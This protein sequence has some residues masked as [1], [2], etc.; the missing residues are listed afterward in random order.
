M[1]L[2][3]ITVHW[4][5]LSAKAVSIND[6]MYVIHNPLVLHPTW[7]SVERFLGEV[8][9][10]STVQGYYQ[11]LTMI[12]LMLD[13]VMGG[14][15]D[16]LRPYHRTS[17]AI[18]A[19]NAALIVILLYMLLG[20][21][22]SA[23]FA[24]LLFGLHP[25]TVET[26]AWCGERK[27]LLATC[28]A[29]LCLI[30]YIRYTRRPATISF[31]ASVTLFLLALMSKPTVTPL[32]VMLLLLDFWP[33]R[34]ISGRA[35]IEKVPFFVLAGVFAIITVV[36]Q[37]HLGIVVHRHATVLQHLLLVCHNLFFYPLKMLWPIPLSSVYPFPEPIGLSHPM[38]LAGL[39]GTC[40][41][42]ALAIASLRWTRA[43]VTCWLLFFVAL[44]PTLLNIKYAMGVAADKYAYLPALGFLIFLAWGLGR[45]T[46][47]AKAW[48]WFAGAA[49]LG[50]AICETALTRSYITTWADTERLCRHVLTVAP[51][52]EWAHSE[53]AVQLLASDD[54]EKAR[55]HASKALALAPG[56]QNAHSA[57]GQILMRQGKPDQAAGHFEQALAAKPDLAE[58]R[59]N[60][61]VCLASTRQLDRAVDQMKW[62]LRDNPRLPEAHFNLGLMLDQQ[63]H[64]NEAAD[65]FAEAINQKPAYP[66]AHFRLAD[67]LSRQGRSP[68]A[69]D[70]YREALKARPDEPAILTHLGIELARANQL[71]EA[72]S[73]LQRA[74]ELA[75]GRPDTHTNLGQALMQAGRLEEAIPQ[76]RAALAMDPNSTKAKAGL[77]AA[78]NQQMPASRPQ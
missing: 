48:Q 3:A 58:A 73:H 53:L 14:S 57:M 35:V 28:F 33:L 77:D 20:E 8:R 74:V 17:L 67:V 70:H 12:S 6:G 24:G 23:A 1:F 45:L 37:Q 36:S 4:P 62:A 66:E 76:Y 34:R 41:M 29:L 47:R 75:P 60:L 59:A 51:D 54:L 21:P 26:M 18:H 64:L 16:N 56:S 43:V 78:L 15:A 50:L 10:P 69:I 22:W 13:T 27:T 7:D 40:V 72:I 25:M 52:T 9:K 68:Q 19:I 32:P 71:P 46:R 65:H 55:Q 44:A 42:I 39:V 49:V 30:T 31:I 2:A 11:P 5:V 63:G 38:V 61:A